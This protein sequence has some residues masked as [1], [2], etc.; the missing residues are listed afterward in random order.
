LRAGLIRIHHHDGDGIQ[1]SYEQF[2]C[3]HLIAW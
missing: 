2:K 3:A 1:N